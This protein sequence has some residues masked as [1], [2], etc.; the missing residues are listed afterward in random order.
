[1]IE[2]GL[3]TGCII[4]FVSMFVLIGAILEGLK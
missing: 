2:R 3:L 4:V 1:M